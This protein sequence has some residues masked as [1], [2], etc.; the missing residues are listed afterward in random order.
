M[1]KEREKKEGWYEIMWCV[2]G[3]TG[4]LVFLELQQSCGES[5][6]RGLHGKW[7]ENKSVKILVCILEQWYDTYRL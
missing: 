3:A 6:E 5:H 2:R 7:K 4:R 1:S